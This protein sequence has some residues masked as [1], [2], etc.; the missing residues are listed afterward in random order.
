MHL[1][2]LV[3]VV[4]GAWIVASLVLGLALARHTHRGYR[5]RL[6]AARRLVMLRV[7]A[8]RSPSDTKAEQ[9]SGRGART[10]V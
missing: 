5:R 9:P 3:L 4:L 8:R 6:G 7:P 2:G 10:T 1:L